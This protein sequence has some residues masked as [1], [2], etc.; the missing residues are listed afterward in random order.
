MAKRPPNLG[1]LV[2][3][4]GNFE[5]YF[6]DKPAKTLFGRDRVWFS[7]RQKGENG[8]KA[9]RT[10]TCLCYVSGLDVQFDRR[11]A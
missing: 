11:G 5:I 9:W 1:K 3:K 10:S 6:F 2:H 4:V 7:I 8:K